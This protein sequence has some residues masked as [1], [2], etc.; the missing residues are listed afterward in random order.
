M[1]AEC[2]RGEAGQSGR[3]GKRRGDPRENRRLRGAVSVGHIVWLVAHPRGPGSSRG[4]RVPCGQGRAMKEILA[5]ALMLLALGVLL[6]VATTRKRRA[7]GF[8]SGQT[9][10]IE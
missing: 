5:L 9:I 7:R 10:A 6:V 2:N 3:T 4:A 1:A 8:G